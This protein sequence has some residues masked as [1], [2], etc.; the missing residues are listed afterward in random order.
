MLLYFLF[1]YWFFCP[2]KKVCRDRNNCGFLRDCVI[3]NGWAFAWMAAS[4][5]SYATSMHMYMKQAIRV[6]MLTLPLVLSCPQS[7][8]GLISWICIRSH[9]LAH[10]GGPIWDG[11]ITDEHFRVKACWVAWTVCVVC[12]FSAAERYVKEG[13]YHCIISLA[14]PF[15]DNAKV[16]DVHEWIVGYG[17]TCL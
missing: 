11:S 16:A 10:S 13:M 8:L 7:P 3:T 2:E 12:Y 1:D 6:W 14:H 17:H 9:H 15:G 4:T 5:L